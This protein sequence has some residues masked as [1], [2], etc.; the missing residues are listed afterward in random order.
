VPRGTT[1]VAAA[2]LVRWPLDDAW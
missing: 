2:W 1:F